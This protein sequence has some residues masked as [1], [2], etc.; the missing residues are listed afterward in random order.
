MVDGMAHDVLDRLLRALVEQ[1]GS[2]LHLKAG[3]PPRI[4]VNGDLVVPVDAGVVSADLA[5]EIARAIMRPQLAEQF[6]VSH[7]VDFA[8]SMGRER[9]RVAA[10]QQRGTAAM[11][12]RRIGTEL[13]SL[14]ELNLPPVVERLADEP[15]GLVLITGPTGSGKTTTLAGMIDRINRRRSCNVI[16][17]EDPIEFVHDDGMA[18]ISQRELGLDFADF[19]SALRASLR[20]DPDVILVGEMRD[21]E[22]IE[23]ALRAASTGHLVLS[24]LHTE[25]AT[26]TANRIVDFFPRTQ[27]PQVR[28]V[29]AGA[30]RGI[31]C[32]RLVARADGQGRVP[33]V[34]TM[35]VNGRIQQCIMDPAYTDR[36]PEI[37]AEGEYY[38]MQTF[39]QHLARLLDEHVIDLQAAM[40]VA[41]NP[42]DLRVAIMRTSG[43]VA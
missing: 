25:N 12:L 13:A 1:D 40:T 21:S 4:R 14:A 26:E 30:L 15:R 32:Q 9:F 5:E 23:T 34:E 28:A 19:S 29:L 16:T 20:Q 11:V 41:S 8:Y 33:V 18:S 3:V 36:M 27:A 10:Y 37:I 31:V 35:V 39:D 43:T 22:T 6:A 42:H 2:D 38:G 7:Q 24:T 17:L